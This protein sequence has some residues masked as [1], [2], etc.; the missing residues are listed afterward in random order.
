MASCKKL[1]VMC[2]HEARNEVDMC[3]HEWMFEIACRALR[4]SRMKSLRRSAEAKSA[5]LAFFDFF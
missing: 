1:R 3:Q 4:G 5:L 2:C